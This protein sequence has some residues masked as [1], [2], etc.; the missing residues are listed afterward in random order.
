MFPDGRTRMGQRGG[1]VLYFALG[2]S[3]SGGIVSLRRADDPAWALD[4]LAARGADLAWRSTR[5]R[6]AGWPSSC[7]GARPTDG[8][9]PAWWLAR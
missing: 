2:A 3:L 8:K 1:A 4:A 6:R 9:R 5:A 7:C